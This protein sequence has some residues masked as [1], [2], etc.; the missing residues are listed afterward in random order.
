MEESNI[1]KTMEDNV[2][3]VIF[4]TK[5]NKV[6]D[7]SKFTS[8]KFLSFINNLQKMYVVLE[9]KGY[10]VDFGIATDKILC[11][12]FNGANSEF[13]EENPFSLFYD[14]SDETIGIV[15]ESLLQIGESSYDNIDLLFNVFTSEY[16][17][18]LPY[19]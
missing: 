16:I 14:Y 3:K 12:I 10:S 6:L 1:T 2:T 8:P 15:D 18:I 5:L 11:N 9:S 7:T 13:S 4:K 17:K 19:N